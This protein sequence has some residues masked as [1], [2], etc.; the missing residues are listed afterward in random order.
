MELALIFPFLKMHNLF[1]IFEEAFQDPA[2]CSA[3]RRILVYGVGFNL[4][5][6][7]SVISWYPGLDAGLLRRYGL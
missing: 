1:E 2:M 5:T 7:F 4:F 6:D 3:P